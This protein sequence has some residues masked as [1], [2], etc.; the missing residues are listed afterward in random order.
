MCYNFYDLFQDEDVDP[1]DAFMV[2]VDRQ[3]H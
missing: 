3:V 1:L 2:Q